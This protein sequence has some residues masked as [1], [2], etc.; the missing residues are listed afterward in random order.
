LAAEPGWWAERVGQHFSHEDR[1]SALPLLERLGFKAESLDW[2]IRRA[3]TGEKQRIA[4]IRMLIQA[5]KVLLLDEPTSALDE[6][7]TG[8]AETILRETL[9]VGGGIII[10]THDRAQGRRLASRHF[11]MNAGT[12]SEVIES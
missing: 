12:L 8:I 3:S 5:P 7:T 10:V 2:E 6:D 1:H 11:T 4:L 9:D